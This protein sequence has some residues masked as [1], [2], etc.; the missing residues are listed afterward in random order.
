LFL[1]NL[2]K[3]EFY[4][5]RK[6]LAKNEMSKEKKG[7]LSEGTLY[8]A[9]ELGNQEW[10]LGFTVGL[11]QKPRRR[12]VAAGDLL[13]LEDEIKLAKKRFG[14]VETAR[15]VSCYEA[16]RDGFWLHRYLLNAG[17]ESMVIDAASIKVDRRAK[18]R[19][20]DRLDLGELL[21]MLIRHDWGEKKVWQVVH[22]PSEEAEDKRH[23]HRQLGTLKVDRTRYVTR[24][25]GLLVTQGVRLAVGSEFLT[26][27][28]QVRLW[29]GRRLPAGLGARL[30]REYAC[31]EFV[32]AQIE[33]LEAERTELIQT[34]TD[35]AVQ[36][37]R[38][39]LRLKG[40]G[41]CSNPTFEK[42]N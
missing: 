14:L 17:L 3:G 32:Q 15:V 39:L 40:L 29:D 41:L 8:L 22:V 37:V 23:L 10:K 35:P 21:P 2:L 42:I 20:T 26:K 12:K 6:E 19:K 36:K 27:L 13:G 1:V 7:N 25:K 24:I 28:E 31:L 18:R 4:P 11:G 16:G 34:S 38:Q 9:F 33:A 5:K 30:Q